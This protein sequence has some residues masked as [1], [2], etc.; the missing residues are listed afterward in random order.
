MNGYEIDALAAQHKMPLG[1]LAERLG[2]GRKKLLKL[3]DM[4]EVPNYDV[5]SIKYFFEHELNQD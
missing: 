5:R 2:I 3:R 1:K 4:D